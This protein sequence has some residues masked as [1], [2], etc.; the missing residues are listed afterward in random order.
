M[1]KT[2]QTGSAAQRRAQERQQRQRRDEGRASV[3]AKGKSVGRGPTIRK[4]DRSR[5]Y[6]I[7]GVLALIAVIIGVLV[8]IAQQPP[9]GQKAT[10]AD[11]TVV[12]QL[13]GVP[14]STWEAIGTAG[15]TNPFK[16][17]SGQPLLSGP[18]GHPQFL[19]IGGE[20]CPNCAAERWSMINALSRFGTFKNL[21]QIQSFENNIS[22]FTFEGSSY[23]SQYVDFVPKEIDG[24]STDAS[25]NH[26]PLDKLTADQQQNLNKYDTS[27][28]IPFVNVGNQYI[29]VGSSYNPQVLLDSSGNPYSYQDIAS[30]LTNTKSPIAQGIL[31]TANYMTAA[32][33]NLTHQQP[34]T[35]CSSPVIQ[36]IEHTLGK[37]SNTAS[38]NSL[39]LAPAD[40][41]AVQRRMLR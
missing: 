24:N 35:A 18:N 39:A 33:C 19:Y 16:P 21:G 1:A 30:A 34:A 12:Q 22:T 31:G 13:I 14:Q 27:G 28:G 36:Q 25:G 32:I 26:P 8:Y 6:M 4:K 11:Q 23:T 5:L 9:A 17:Q 29:A 40:L 15:L 38:N 7:I 10:P 20:Y 41:I 2:K 37:T 3:M